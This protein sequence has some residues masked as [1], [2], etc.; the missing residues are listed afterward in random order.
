MKI[1]IF[2]ISWTAAAIM[3]IV[4]SFFGCSDSKS[5]KS[6]YLISVTNLTN[7]QL[8]SPPAFILHD[9]EY[10]AW[11]IGTS[12]SA[13]LEELAESGDPG[14]FLTEAADNM[15]VYASS[16]GSSVIGPGNSENVEIEA[17]RNTDTHLSF[18][19][20]LVNTNDAM[21]GVLDAS[22]GTLRI[23]ESITLYGISYDAGT[24]VNS[25]TAESVPG[26]AA[27]GEGFNPVRDDTG[28]VA[29]HSG[30]V[31]AADGLLAS[32]LDESHRWQNPVVR[33][34]VTRTK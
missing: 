19:S 16:Q 10:A 4:F 1:K 15:H 9:N 34:I 8:L 13:G 25:E 29:A 33:L 24:E 3:L 5:S 11:Q 2:K 27:G 17:R 31:T 12:A 22:I 23:N 30:V 7:N 18:I 26:P 6:S 14:P 21:A 20:M 32:A 28:F